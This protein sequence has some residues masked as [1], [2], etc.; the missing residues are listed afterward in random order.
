[1]IVSVDQV[2]LMNFF[3]K[4]PQ[5][6]SIAFTLKGYAI[7]GGDAEK[8]YRRLDRLIWDGKIRVNRRASDAGFKAAAKAASYFMGSDN[9][10]LGSGFRAGGIYGQALLAHEGAHALIDL[11][12]L[13]SIDR[14]V[15][16]AI[17]YLAEAM[18]LSLTGYE[19]I[20]DE[21][22][23]PNPVRVEAMALAGKTLGGSNRQV[24]DADA[25]KLAALIRQNK[26]YDDPSPHISNGIG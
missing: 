24:A 4:D 20:M 13:G 11:Q 14:G 23:T 18:W 22:S 19:A 6:P 16:E 10:S 25:D 21:G 7:A 12:K 9:F 26:Q 1:M 5:L 8:G 2:D 15:S 3:G 17:G